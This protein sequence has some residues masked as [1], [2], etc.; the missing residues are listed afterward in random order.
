MLTSCSSF[1]PENDVEK[2]KKDTVLISVKVD[3]LIYH[4]ESDLIIK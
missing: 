2:E 3:T 4:Y 1:I